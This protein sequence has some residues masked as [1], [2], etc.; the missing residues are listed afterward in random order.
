[1]IKELWNDYYQSIYA[2]EDMDY[3]V[4]DELRDTFYAGVAAIIKNGL[5]IDDVGIEL[6]EFIAEQLKIASDT[7]E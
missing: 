7:L 5:T 1:M 2:D 6:D 3:E 4:I